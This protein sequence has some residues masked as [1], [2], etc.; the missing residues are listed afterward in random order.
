VWNTLGTLNDHIESL[1]RSAHSAYEHYETDYKIV[2]NQLAITKAQQW[3][4][5]SWECETQTKIAYIFYAMYDTFLQIRQWMRIMGNQVQVPIEPEEQ[6]RLLDT[7]LELPGVL[8]ANV[9]G[10]KIMKEKL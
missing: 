2:L 6:T 8:C 10:G 9:P 7:T 1:I 5:L 4:D 3:S